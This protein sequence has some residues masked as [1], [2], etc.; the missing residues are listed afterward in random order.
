MVPPVYHLI[1]IPTPPVQR[2]AGRQASDPLRWV[3]FRVAPPRECVG[4]S[5]VK[6]KTAVET[7]TNDSSHVRLCCHA[8]TRGPKV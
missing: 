7:L 8:D 6:L 3:S 1:Q 2:E 4:H 5:H